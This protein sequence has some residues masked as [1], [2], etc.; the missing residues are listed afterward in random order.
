MNQYETNKPQIRVA[1]S[2]WVRTWWVFSIV[3]NQHIWWRCLGGNNTR[4]LGHKTS[5]IHFTLM[6]D[7]DFN[8]NL[9]ADRPKPSKLCIDINVC[10]IYRQIIMIIL[11]AYLLC[12]YHNEKHQT[13]HP[14]LEAGQKQSTDGS[15]HHWCGYQGWDGEPSSLCLQAYIKERSIVRNYP[16][17]HEKKNYLVT[18]GSHWAV[19]EGHSRACV[20]TKS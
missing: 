11:T 9:S 10:I 13:G 14:H 7:L 6:I 8:F 19:S 18:S 15:V 20:I 17:C 16:N 1:L 4:I 12:H 2:T 5:P 3:K